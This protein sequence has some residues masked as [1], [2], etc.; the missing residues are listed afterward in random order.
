MKACTSIGAPV[1]W[2]SIEAKISALACTFASTCVSIGSPPSSHWQ[3]FSISQVFS[4]FGWVISWIFCPCPS[5]L[6]WRFRSLR[7]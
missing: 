1:R 6:R 2:L 3:N 4:H 7:G 5:R